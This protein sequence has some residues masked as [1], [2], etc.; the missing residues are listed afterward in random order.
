MDER[1]QLLESFNYQ[2]SFV[3]G[4]LSHT[5]RV[6]GNGGRSGV[7]IVMV[8]LFLF[9][10]MSNRSDFQSASFTDQTIMRF[11][12]AQHHTALAL[13]FAGHPETVAVKR[14]VCLHP[15]H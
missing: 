9:L 10:L 4:L 14:R 1:G 5:H 13:T 7:F 11:R 6:H 8:R 15:V 2:F 3:V 12:V